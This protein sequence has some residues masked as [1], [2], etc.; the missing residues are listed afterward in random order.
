M[1]DLRMSAASDC[2]TASDGATGP[3]VRVETAA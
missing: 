3:A 2:P 1:H